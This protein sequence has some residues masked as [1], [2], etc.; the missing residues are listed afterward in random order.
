MRRD[1]SQE[2]TKDLLKSLGIT[3]V[4]PDGKHIF[5][6]GEELKLQ[7]INKKKGYLGVVI[8]GKRLDEDENSYINLCMHVA[9]YVWNKGD[10][11]NG[12]V[13]DHID[14]NP[15]N[16]DISNLQLI[17]QSEN[18]AKNIPGFGKARVRMPKY[19]TLEKIQQKLAYY[20]ELYEQAK[21]DH[22]AE[23][24]H[25]LRSNV[26]S[27][28]SKLRQYLECPEKYTRPDRKF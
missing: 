8:Y 2:I 1:Y 3:E 10:R 9:N 17:T 4:T 25:A 21:R 24:C 6:N 11:K 13:V 27:W 28:K 18:L 7:V 14:N 19:I 23:R 15:L 26:G 20:T 5:R 22:D 12:L 16:N